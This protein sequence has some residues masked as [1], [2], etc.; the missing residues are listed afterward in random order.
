MAIALLGL[1]IGVDESTIYYSIFGG[2]IAYIVHLVNSTTIDELFSLSKSFKVTYGIYIFIFIILLVLS[3]Y[4][5]NKDISNFVNLNNKIFNCVQASIAS[6]GISTFFYSTFVL[7]TNYIIMIKK[8][9]ENWQ[10]VNIQVTGLIKGLMDSINKNKNK[11]NN[12]YIWKYR[13]EDANEQFKSLYNIVLDPKQ[14]LSEKELY[15]VSNK[16]LRLLNSIKQIK[17]E[18]NI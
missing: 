15:D 2:T 1:R 4:F 6:W 14:K 10:A 5:S 17:E 16:M 7:L 9:R 3:F 11:I 18:F 12:I 8:S 13:L